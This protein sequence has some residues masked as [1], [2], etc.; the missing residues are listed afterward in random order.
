MQVSKIQMWLTSSSMSL[1]LITKTQT[2]DIFRLRQFPDSITLG[3]HVRKVQRLKLRRQLM[4]SLELM[5]AMMN[6]RASKWKLLY[7]KETRSRT[8]TSRRDYK[9]IWASELPK[10]RRIKMVERRNSN[11]RRRNWIRTSVSRSTTGCYLTSWRNRKL[12]RWFRNRNS[13]KRTWKSPRRYITVSVALEYSY[14]AF[15]EKLSKEQ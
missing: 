14:V 4:R 12:S 5:K 1:T 11:L 3:K 10:P 9:L 7:P 13:V 15:I 6:S 2:K 8:R